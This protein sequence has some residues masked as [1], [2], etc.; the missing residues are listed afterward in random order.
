MSGIEQLTT[1]TSQLQ[2]EKDAAR[3][4]F[5]RARGSEREIATEQQRAN[6]ELSSVREREVNLRV[7]LEGKLEQALELAFLVAERLKEG[8]EELAAA[9]A[10]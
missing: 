1:E 10:V 8:R 6:A 4:G 5:D 2:S 7:R 9:V 3:E